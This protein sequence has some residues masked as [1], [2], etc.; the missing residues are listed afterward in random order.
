MPKS[1]SLRGNP[2]RVIE[3]TCR[4]RSNA[5]HSLERKPEIAPAS[6]AK[7]DVQPMPGFIGDMPVPRN[8]VAQQL[9]LIL[10]INDFRAEGGA[11]PALAP[12]AVAH[13]HAQRGAQR[14][15]SD[16]A[17][18]TSALALFKTNHGRHLLAAGCHHI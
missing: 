3:R 8:S 9:D 17:A 18:D 12:C 16:A 5:R 13:G 14:S 11:G 6:A 4:Q 7:L 2:T 15:K 1:V 10:V